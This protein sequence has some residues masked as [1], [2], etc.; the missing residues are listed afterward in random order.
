M[1]FHHCRGREQLLY[2]YQE[3]RVLQCHTG[4]LHSAD[5]CWGHAAS[6]DGS[7]WRGGERSPLLPLCMQCSP[8]GQH[9]KDHG[10]LVTPFHLLLGNM[11][12]SP[13]LNI[14]PSIFCLTQTCP[15]SSSYCPHGTW[16]L[17]PIQMVTLLPSWT[18]SPPQ[19]EATQRVAP[20]EP[21][22]SKRRD[23]M[24]LHKAL[25]RGW[26]EA[27]AR[28]SDL[29]WKAREEHYKT[30]HPHF[31]CETSHNLM[32]VFQGMI[33]SASLLGSQ[34]YEIQDFWEGPIDLRYTNNAFRA[35]PKGL[36][37]F[38]AVS[39]SKLPKVM[40]LAG[41]HNPDALHHF[42]G[43]TFCPWC[44]KEGQNE[45]TIINHLCSPL[46]DRT[47]LWD[48]VPLSLSYL[49]SH[50]ARKVASIPKGKTG[51]WTTHLHLPSHLKSTTDSLSFCYQH[52]SFYTSSY[53]KSYLNCDPAI[54]VCFHTLV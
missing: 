17:I 50:L 2:G 53:E 40:G 19:S 13:L 16:A 1:C 10:V 12:L 29:V 36:W 15:T 5:T 33:T 9:P 3:G 34:I 48:M 14:P 18:V 27:F 41:I 30:N 52:W 32:S 42:S 23:E 26:C 46:Q 35:L 21:P 31:D 7:H 51:V 39:P 49:W 4:P 11:P 43:M 20:E 54:C 8:M 45:G 38:H 44:G 37:F 22:H 25:T 6:W 24:P 47:S 28:D